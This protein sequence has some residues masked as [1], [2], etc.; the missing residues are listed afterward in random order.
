MAR[1]TRSRSRMDKSNSVQPAPLGPTGSTERSG[2][3]RCLAPGT[4]RYSCRVARSHGSRILQT[5]NPSVGLA[6]LVAIRQ[7]SPAT[8]NGALLAITIASLRAAPSAPKPAIKRPARTASI[9]IRATMPGALRIPSPT[10]S[11]EPLAAVD[12]T[13]LVP[14]A[15]PGRAPSDCRFDKQP[16]RRVCG[17]HLLA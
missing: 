17:A 7:D 15:A 9:T 3:P 13:A 8:G 12:P 11:E 10:A 14:G 4:T 2:I 16:G 1:P 5:V 6:S